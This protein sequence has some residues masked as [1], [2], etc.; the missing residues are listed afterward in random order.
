MGERPPGTTIDRVDNDGNYEPGNCRWA[1]HREQGRNR[2]TTKLDAP[3]VAQI[4]ARCAAGE[5]HRAV[6][7]D[8]GVARSTVTQIVGG[9]RWA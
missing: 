4:R 6:A 8:F 5:L 9:Q 3:A 1:T 7:Q 2:R